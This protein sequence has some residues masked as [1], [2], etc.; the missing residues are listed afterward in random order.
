MEKILINLDSRHRDTSLY[1]TSSFFRIG[2]DDQN[3]SN[4]SN[5]LNFKNIDYI[6]LVSAEIPN[7]FYVFSDSKYNNFFNIK[8]TLNAGQTKNPDINTGAISITLPT[9]TFDADVLCNA[10]NIILKNNFL[11]VGV[12]SNN[13]IITITDG[14]KFSVNMVIN[15]FTIENMSTNYTFEINFNNSN[16]DYRSFGYMIGYKENTINFPSQFSYTASSCS[17]IIGERYI[18]IRINNFGLTYINHKNPKKVLAKIILDKY[19]QDFIYSNNQ[20][21]INKEHKFRLPVNINR[22]EIELLDYNGNRLDNNG[23]DFSITLEL[24]QIYDE[25]LYN[26]TFDY[27]KMREKQSDELTLDI[28]NNNETVISSDNTQHKMLD[29]IFEKIKPEIIPVPEIINLEDKR[30]KNIKKKKKKINFDY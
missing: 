20:D 11:S 12:I 4:Y 14:L 15:K 22:L 16:I 21:Q 13:G 2:S 23:L 19:K 18:F 6:K 8:C 28:I 27:I 7:I 17:D 30:Q 25:R 9:G 3:N 5:Y 1:P 26:K 10:I 29:N 24:G